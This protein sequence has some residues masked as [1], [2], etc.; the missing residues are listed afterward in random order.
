MRRV[1]SV[2]V[3]FA[4][5]GFAAAQNVSTQ[6]TV[7]R[8]TSIVGTS[9]TLQ[10]ESIGKVVD[11]VISDDGCI[12]Y[13]VVAYNDK[14]IPVPYSVVRVQPNSI[15]ITSQNITRQQLA[16]LAFTGTNYVG[17]RDAAF[18]RSVQQVYG[19]AAIRSS[20]TGVG[21]KSTDTTPNT[22]KT[23]EPPKLNP[24]KSTTDT[25][26]TKDKTS[27]PTPKATPAKDKEPVP[28]KVTP[29]KVNP[30]KEN[31]AKD[32]KSDPGTSSNTDQP[33][34]RPSVSSPA[35]PRLAPEDPKRKKDEIAP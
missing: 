21:G 26:A 23:P 33:Q 29:P 22:N 7:I 17:F 11:L 12:E 4:A 3:L 8:S 18:A 27:D 25:P 24:N 32:K 30:P 2:L 31:P 14:Y 15:V 16:G 35:Q 6:T 19:Q 28:P 13:L 9:V 34:P 10:Q 5:A 20:G 1:L